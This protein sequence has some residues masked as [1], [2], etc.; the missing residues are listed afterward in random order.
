MSRGEGGTVRIDEVDMKLLKLLKENSRMSYARLADV[1][2]ISESAV[3]KRVNKLRKSGVIR[4][5][6]IEYELA[7]EVRAVI[8]VKT[9]P[10]K[11]VPEVSSQI[12]KIEGVETVY[13]VTGDNDILVMVRVQSIAEVNKCIDKIRSIPGVASTNTM[14]ILRV[15]T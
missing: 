12:I 3:R 8:L 15:W 5:F 4:K 7:N 2:G 6:T 13:E 10:P 14:I 11:P 9:T 1:L